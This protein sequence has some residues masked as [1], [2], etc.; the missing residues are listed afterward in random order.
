MPQSHLEGYLEHPRTKLVGLIDSDSKALVGLSG[1]VP[2]SMPIATSVHMVSAMRPDIVS[3]ATPEPT[4]V[5][6]VRQVLSA[7]TPR[8]IFLEKPIAT[9]LE[10]AHWIV[11]EC[12]D[13]GVILQV[14]HARAWDSDVRRRE[15]PKEIRHGGPPWRNDVHA[16]HLASLY[17]PRPRVR[18]MP[19]RG[20][21]VDEEPLYGRLRPGTITKAISDLLHAIEYGTEPK[22]SGE[23]ATRAV[24]ETLRSR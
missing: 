2:G 17:D 13:R 5:Q 24:E 10:G 11:E 23:V 14:N 3:I 21:T 7:I 12:K 6:I 19:E 15:P 20:L 8:G 18:P 4:H 22:C 1:R 16:Y 9:T